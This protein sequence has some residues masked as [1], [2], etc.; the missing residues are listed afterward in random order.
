VLPFSVV[1][2]PASCCPFPVGKPLGLGLLAVVQ[3]HLNI[4]YMEVIL[5]LK[6]CRG[7]GLTPAGQAFFFSTSLE[8]ERK[9]Y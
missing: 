8:D 4:G 9:T 3:F 2:L 1:G 5:P 6:Q 7:G